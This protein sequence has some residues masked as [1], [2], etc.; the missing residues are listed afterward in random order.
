MS[1]KAYG[2]LLALG[3]IWGASFMFIK[4]GGE[5]MEPFF[6]VEVRLALA[7][8]TLLLLGAT[9]RGTFAAMRAHWK[10]LLVMGLINCALP[11]TLITWGEVYISSGLAAIYN[12]CAPLWAAALGL[13]W[14]WGERLSP[15]RL[16]GLLVGLLGVGLIVSG[17]LQGGEGVMY[18]LGQG[19]VLLAALSYA[20][21]GIYGRHRL[22]DVPVRVSA[23]GQL[24]F[25]ALIILP[26]A[27]L[28]VPAQMPSWLALGSIA[29]L[30]I[31]GTAVASLLY[32][33]LL[34][35]VGS[36]GALLVTYLL[37]GFALIWGAIF[38]NEAI[39]LIAVVG[40]VLVLLG[41]TITSGRGT[42]LL[43]RLLR[44][45]RVQPTP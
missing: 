25:G 7:S 4:V 2:V 12:A 21:S 26:L 24:T 13:V 5:E 8:L 14:S 16:V 35:N 6:L 38:L 17:N 33:W 18:L 42:D 15:T 29:T 27:A 43:S 9:Q 41:I 45:N 20:V 39:T 19:A 22:K 31:L 30:A 3:A 40:L 36:T 1:A 32:Y 23:T 10:P 11:Y 34:T 37:P 44:R 28:Q